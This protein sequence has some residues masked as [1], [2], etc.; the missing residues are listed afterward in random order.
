MSDIDP[1]AILQEAR[2]QVSQG[3]Y[4]PALKAYRWFHDHALE[5]D[6]SLNGIRRSF[7]LR[8]WMELGTLYPPAR[9]ELE[10]I[11]DSKASA[12]ESG[13]NDPKWF[14]D[15]SAINEILGEPEKTGSLFSIIADQDPSLARQCFPAARGSLV[16][17]KRYSL[18]RRFIGS[19]EQ[20]LSKW[21]GRINRNVSQ[22]CINQTSSSGLI[23]TAELE[24]Y[25]EDVQQLF[26]ILAG[27]GEVQEFEHLRSVAIEGVLDPVIRDWVREKLSGASLET[28]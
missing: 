27:V 8:Y 3:A 25:V 12:L 13:L 21:L 24:I 20:M 6:P 15:V 2:Q 4:E 23:E 26:A 22:A 28:S 16:I 10:S 19:P 18:A 9:T 7:A 14:R 17:T 1:I 5:H 11:R